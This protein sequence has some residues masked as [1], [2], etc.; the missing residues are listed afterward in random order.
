VAMT[1]PLS[2]GHVDNRG[3]VQVFRPFDDPAALRPAGFEFSTVNDLARF[4]M[5]FLNEGKIEGKQ[6]FS[7]G[8]ITKLATPYVPMH[9]HP[10]P[11]PMEKGMYGYGLMIHVER[12]VRIVEHTG[13]LPGF[14]CRL[15][16][17]PEHRLA[18]IVMTN[19]TG[20]TLNQTIERVMELMLPLKPKAQDQKL[21]RLSEAE[22]SRYVGV[23]DNPMQSRVEV[24]S[25]NGELIFKVSGNEFTMTRIGEHRFSIPRPTANE[26][27][28]VMGA[29]GKAQFRHTGLRAWK[30]IQT[31]RITK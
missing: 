17:V 30:R 26:I 3:E 29:D 9:S 27:A 5:A 22:M 10:N 14:G 20:E 4:A 21:A 1:Y 2:Q 6:V 23:Y 28:F 7:P 13:V 12:G 15:L 31:T 8:V 18:I 25:K 11:I 16:I 24:I 19:R